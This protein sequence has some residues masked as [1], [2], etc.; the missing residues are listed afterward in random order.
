MQL[1]ALLPQQALLLGSVLERHAQRRDEMHIARR[2]LARINAALE[3]ANFLD[4][5]RLHAQS[6]RRRALDQVPP[7]G[8]PRIKRQPHI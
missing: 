7:I 2:L 4:S 1:D 6:T 8:K 5:S 3:Q